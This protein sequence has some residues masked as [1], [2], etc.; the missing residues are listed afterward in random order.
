MAI[1]MQLHWP[2]A[3]VE[4]YEEV[5]ARA[6]W[7]G[8]RPQGGQV[9]IVGW[10]DDGMRITDIWDSAEDFQA[11]FEARVLPVVQDAGMTTE[12]DVKIFELHGVYAPA[13]GRVAQTASV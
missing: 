12:P 10:A 1:V 7:E 5:R 8:D 6:D 3:T 9:H 2:E 4:L 13:F 11:F